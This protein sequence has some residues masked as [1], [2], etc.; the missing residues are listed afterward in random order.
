MPT[1]LTAREVHDILNIDRSTVYRMAE[2]GRLPG[3]RIGRQWRFPSADIRSLAEGTGATRTGG[4]FDSANARADG[5]DRG[6]AIAVIDVSAEL[7]DVMMV[8]T[9]MAGEPVTAV[10][11]PCRWFVEHGDEPGV[12]SQCVSEWRDLAEEHNFQPEFRVGELGFECAR[13]F[14]RSGRAL[15][16][17]VLAGGVC[18]Q[19]LKSAGLYE[20][21]DAQRNRVITALPRIA[22]VISRNARRTTDA[23]LKESS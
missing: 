9:D 16:G 19:G 20:L 13:A 15:V 12:M 22:S 17:M 4:G 1:L 3:I 23:S 11:N 18:P 10:V 14:I 21:D 2:S 7:L 8:V 5:P 6:T